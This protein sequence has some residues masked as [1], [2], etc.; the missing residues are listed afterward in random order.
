MALDLVQYQPPDFLGSYLTGIRA[1]QGL[2]ALKQAKMETAEKQA[3]I[4]TGKDATAEAEQSKLP[5]TNSNDI[6]RVP[7]ASMPAEK[8]QQGL[9]QGALQVQKLRAMGYTDA[10]NRLAQGNTQ[11][12]LLQ[13][14]LQEKQHAQM[15]EHLGQGLGQLVAGNPN[16]KDIANQFIP[17]GQKIIDFQ[18]LNSKDENGNWD[19]SI[20]VKDQQHPQGIKE[21]YYDILKSIQGAQATMQQR[22]MVKA[23]TYRADATKEN[24]KARIEAEKEFKGM[25]SEEQQ[26]IIRDYERK[27]EIARSVN[28]IAGYENYIAQAQ[29]YREIA[30]NLRAKEGT[31]AGKSGTKVYTANPEETTNAFATI[32]TVLPDDLAKKIDADKALQTKM[33]G[34][35]GD[36]VADAKEMAANTKISY[37]EAKRK[38]I[39]HYKDMGRF[40]EGKIGSW[41]PYESTTPP[42]YNPNAGE[43]A[44]A[45]PHTTTQVDNTGST[46]TEGTVPPPDKRTIGHVYMTPKGPLKW[47]KDGWVQF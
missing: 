21:N 13:V 35:A 17:D 29:K 47:T 19:G 11:T 15:M 46:P 40:T 38:V 45:V 36:I 30:A 25:K 28:D 16:G 22:E 37:T 18:K 1:A 12:K 2:E 32:K 39:Q 6:D 10:A 8:P 14:D 31:G 43:T 5:E 34:M 3:L 42:N 20:F 23:W 7:D 4:S 9:D 24:T 26:G 27:A 44:P 41:I 33:Y